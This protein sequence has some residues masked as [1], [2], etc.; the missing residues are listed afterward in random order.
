[1]SAVLSLV[2]FFY[3]LLLAWFRAYL[4]LGSLGLWVVHSSSWFICGLLPF[5]CVRVAAKGPASVEASAQQPGQATFCFQEASDSVT[6][7]GKNPKSP[8]K[9]RQDCRLTE[10]HFKT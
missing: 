3:G 9:E 7:S 6:S 4:V 10:T 2:C 1:M 5:V 8:M